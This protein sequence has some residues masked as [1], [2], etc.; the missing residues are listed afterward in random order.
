ML[1]V[2]NCD[3]SFGDPDT[4]LVGAYDI[5]KFV[6]AHGELPSEYEKNLLCELFMLLTLLEDKLQ[7]AVV[8]AQCTVNSM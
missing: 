5:I 3:N 4:V 7:P 6:I 8:S 1:A 2:W